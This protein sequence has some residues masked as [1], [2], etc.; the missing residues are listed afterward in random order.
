MSLRMA[1]ILSI[2]RHRLRRTAPK[3]K[4]RYS[5]RLGLVPSVNRTPWDAFRLKNTTTK[6][7]LS[8]A[9]DLG[10]TLAL[11]GK[12]LRCERQIQEH[13]PRA[14]GHSNSLNGHELQRRKM[15]PLC[16]DNYRMSLAGSHSWLPRSST[17]TFYVR[18]LKD[19]EFLALWL[20]QQCLCFA[21]MFLLG[22][23][24]CLGHTL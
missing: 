17:F 6:C 2:A 19:G 14:H 1:L 12:I 10:V 23:Y 24:L 15:N 21:S 20:L 3:P 16:S 13:P 9:N 4:D 18:T 11:Q 5:V 22:G 8:F 7:N